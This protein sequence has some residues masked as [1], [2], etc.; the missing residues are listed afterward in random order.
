MVTMGD[1]KLVRACLP[2]PGLDESKMYVGAALYSFKIMA[3]YHLDRDN[4]NE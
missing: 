4:V 3:G 1:R 2:F